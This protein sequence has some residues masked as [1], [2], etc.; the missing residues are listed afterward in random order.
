MQQVTLATVVFER[1][2]Y[3]PPAPEVLLRP[4]P[5]AALKDAAPAT[6]NPAQ[7]PCN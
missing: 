4:A 5:P 2:G 3:Q 6:A 7:P 1:Y